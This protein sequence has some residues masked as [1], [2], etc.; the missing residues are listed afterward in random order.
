MECKE[1]KSSEA[2]SDGF[3]FLLYDVRGR[4]NLL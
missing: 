1:E 3:A 4:F 2:V